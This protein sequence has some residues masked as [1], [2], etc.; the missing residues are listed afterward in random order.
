MWRADARVRLLA[1]SSPPTSTAAC[2]NAALKKLFSDP[3]FNVM[4][5]L[6]TYIDDYGKPDPLPPVMLRRMAQSTFLGLFDDE[7]PR[8]TQR[9]AAAGCTDAERSAQAD[10]AAAATACAAKPRTHR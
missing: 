8:R 9:R 4:D 5:G 6:D 2:S 7:Q 1:A 10:A 3:H